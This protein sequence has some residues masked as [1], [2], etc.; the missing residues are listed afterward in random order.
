VGS[1]ERLR[2]GELWVGYRQF[3]MLYLFPLVLHAHKGVGFQPWLRGSIDG[4]TATQARALLSLR[5]CFR[6]GLTTNVFL[7]ARLERRDSRSGAA[8][9]RQVRNSG[10]ERQ[11]I[12][13]NVRKMRKLVDR[14]QWSPPP[15]TWVDY[16]EDNTYDDADAQ[17]KDAFVRAVATSE[18]W[19]LVW[20]LGAN[21][22]RHARI[23]AE[24]ARHVVAIDADEGPIELLYRELRD[25]G[26]QRILP[27]TMNLADPSPGLGWRGRERKAL[28]DRGRPDLV[29]A[30]ALVHHVVIGANVPL[31]EFV[32]WLAELGAALVIEFPMREDPMV[33][34]LLSR[35]REGLHADY[36]RATFERVLG[37][38]FDIRRTEEL[39]SGTRVLY[40]ATRNGSH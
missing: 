8:I 30:L 35:K 17:R 16:G 37:D 19:E 12:G 22:G 25:A 26:D 29:L 33:Q 39:G 38:A 11:L 7:H 2:P 32:D 20:D 24:G 15:G 40:F 14:L 21:N 4:I 18:P 23:A 5:D 27:L 10:A 34:G 28:L 13:A 6:R 3:C 1:F 36:D 9:K 31:A